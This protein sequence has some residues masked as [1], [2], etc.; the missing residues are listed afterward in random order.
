M[1]QSNI[2]IKY[3]PSCVLTHYLIQ[4]TVSLNFIYTVLDMSMECEYSLGP[5][6]L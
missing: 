3:I 4:S 5:K 1:W 2:E 6:L